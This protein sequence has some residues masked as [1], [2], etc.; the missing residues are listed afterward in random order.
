MH[1]RVLINAHVPYVPRA[2]IYYATSVMTVVV[3]TRA[4]HVLTILYAEFVGKTNFLGV[5]TVIWLAKNAKSGVTSALQIFHIHL[6]ELSATLVR[7]G[8][9]DV[10]TIMSK[11]RHI[12]EIICAR[13][14]SLKSVHIVG[15]E[16]INMEELS[17]LCV[18]LPRNARSHVAR[19]SSSDG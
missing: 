5:I 13:S 9:N 8:V 15:A 11:I 1:R 2:N 19:M 10:W 16:G 18:G 14:V 3:Q 7:A 6:R 4:Q 12:L 17:V